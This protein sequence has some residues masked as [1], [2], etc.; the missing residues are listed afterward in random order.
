MTIREELPSIEI[1][2]LVSKAFLASPVF[3]GVDEARYQPASILR[4]MESGRTLVARAESAIGSITLFPVNPEC[5]CEAFR[6]NPSFGLLAVDPAH[7]GRGIARDLIAAV[8][9]LAAQEGHK[10]IALSVTQRGQSLIDFYR[11]L[12]YMAI[13]EFH[14]PAAIDPSRILIK[15]LQVS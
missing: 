9:E 5:P 13:G 12:G 3:V 1:A 2:S 4:L 6:S 10:A 15:S 11:R 14:W 8:E 7:H